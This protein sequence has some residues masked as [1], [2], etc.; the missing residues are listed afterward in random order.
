M[1]RAREATLWETDMRQDC[2]RHTAEEMIEKD[3]D[4]E[5]GDWTI[6]QQKYL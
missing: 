2:N 4:A 6:D 3:S 5:I 1:K